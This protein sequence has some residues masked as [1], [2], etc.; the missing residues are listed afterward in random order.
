MGV[1]AVVGFLVARTSRAAAPSPGTAA[2]DYGPAANP[3]RLLAG[4]D[5]VAA[6]GG[7]VLADDKVVLTLGGDNTVQGF[8]AVCTHQGCTVASVADGTI[9]CPCHGSRFDAQTG[10]VV[11]GPATRSL[12]AVPVVVRDGGVYTM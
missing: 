12:P 3:G 5:E 1:A 7:L 10:A 6:A 11:S 4:L 9:D 2:N 8:S